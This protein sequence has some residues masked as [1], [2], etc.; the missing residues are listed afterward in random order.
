MFRKCE[1]RKAQW[2]IFL[3]CFLFAYRCS[4]HSNTGFSPFQIIFGKPARGPLDVLREGWLEG[5]VQEVHVEWVNKL[6]ERLKEMMQVVCEKERLAKERMKKHYDKN[7]KLRE[8]NEGALVL[9]RT[10]D[11]AGKLEDIWEGP[12]E[13]TRR[14][15]SVTYELAVPTRWTRN[16]VV[17]INML[18]AWKSPEAPVFRVIVAEEDEC[19]DDQPGHGG[20]ELAQKQAQELQAVPKQFSDAI[21]E[22]TGKAHDTDH[23]IDT[24]EH[25][26]IRSVPY[27]LASAW[28]EQLRVEVL[29]LLELG[30]VIPSLSPWSSPMVPVKKPGG[31][32]HLC[33]DFRKVNS[34]TT[35]DHMPCP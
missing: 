11:L 28:K 23:G 22:T 25:T 34:I 9:V 20:E 1:G 30:I 2:D 10:P 7:A 33:I 31:S 6:S 15:S 14:I 24:G 26:P 4:P 16:R 32:V 8:F 21:C 27:R 12:Y 18:K 19:E 29:S 35:P 3:K 13:I 5:E 17:H